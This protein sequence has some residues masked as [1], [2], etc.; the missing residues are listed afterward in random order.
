MTGLRVVI[1]CGLAG[2]VTGVVLAAA[3]AVVFP[4][5]IARSFSP[6]PGWVR[7]TTEIVTDPAT[8]EPAELETMH[9]QGGGTVVLPLR[10]VLPTSAVNLTPADLLRGAVIGGAVGVLVGTVSI[11]LTGSRRRRAETLAS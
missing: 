8:G 2:A 9:F 6:P 1:V 5:Q 3:L 10:P 4:E 7:S 11:W